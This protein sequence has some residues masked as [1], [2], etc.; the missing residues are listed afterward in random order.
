MDTPHRAELEAARAHARGCGESTALRGSRQLR[1]LNCSND[2]SFL[3]T[4]VE[5]W[6]IYMGIANRPG[7]TPRAD[8]R[9]V[10]PHRRPNAELRSREYLTEVDRLMKAAKLNRHG[11]RDATMILLTFRHGLR[12]AE[13]VDLRWDQVSFEKAILAVRR[14]KGGS[15]STHP[16]S[17]LELRALRKVKREA[18]ASPFVFLSERAAPF[19]PAGFARLV[20]RAAVAAALNMKVHPHMLRHGCGFKLANDGVDTRSLQQYLGHRNIQH[21]V[22]YTELSAD[23]FRSFWRE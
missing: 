15:P 10:R 6:G 18:P 1:L 7:I 8:N 17:G 20:E 5:Q 13:V 4:A 16:L 21:T 9:T 23:R 3:N 14:V 12:A 19:S 2:A 22:R 11:H